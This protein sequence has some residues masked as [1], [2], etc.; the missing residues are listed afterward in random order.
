MHS[1]VK[2]LTAQSNFFVVLSRQG[3]PDRGAERDVKLGY[4]ESEE[5]RLSYSVPNIPATDHFFVKPWD[6]RMSNVRRIEYFPTYFDGAISDCIINS[7]LPRKQ[8]KWNRPTIPHFWSTAYL[9]R[10]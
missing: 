4:S 8:Q 5:G 3:T 2:D 10:I 6:G 9:V 1:S 7:G